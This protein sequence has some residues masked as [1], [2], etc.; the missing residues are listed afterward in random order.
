MELTEMH[1]EIRPGAQGV[2]RGQR[3]D[4]EVLVE[5]DDGREVRLP[6]N[7]LVRIDRKRITPDDLSGWYPHVFEV[8]EGYHRDRIVQQADIDGYHYELRGRSGRWYVTRAYVA[9]RALDSQVFRTKFF[10]NQRL[11]EEAFNLFV[12]G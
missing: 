3:Q 4:G 8:R 11:A 1:N 10:Q 2:S 9:G 6:L 7:K 12:Y 5:L